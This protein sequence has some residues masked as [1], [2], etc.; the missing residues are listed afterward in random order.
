MFQSHRIS[1]S[2]MLICTVLLNGCAAALPSPFHRTKSEAEPVPNFASVVMSP[3]QVVSRSEAEEEWAAFEQSV[4]ADL[5]GH[6]STAQ[7][8]VT[9]TDQARIPGTVASAVAVTLNRAGPYLTEIFAANLHALADAGYE[10]FLDPSL[11]L[12]TE[13]ATPAAMVSYSLPDAAIGLS[14]DLMVLQYVVAAPA[15]GSY[16]MY[17]LTIEED[18][19][20]TEAPAFG[21]GSKHFTPGPLTPPNR[22]LEPRAH[23]CSPKRFSPRQS[24]S[25]AMIPPFRH[26]WV[27]GH[28]SP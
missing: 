5:D 19:F 25:G 2:I 20:A 1:L 4:L 28:P 16:V 24:Q 12:A 21:S 6:L 7:L 23:R 15:Q 9:L 10:T 11:D 27:P 22:W 3:W 14:A 13:L 17:S 26:G 18:L 8:E